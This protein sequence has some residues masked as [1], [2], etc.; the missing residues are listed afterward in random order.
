MQSLSA[1]TVV[2]VFNLKKHSANV[3]ARSFHC[4]V[5]KKLFKGQRQT[6]LSLVV[7]CPKDPQLLGGLMLRRRPTIQ[8]SHVGDGESNY[9]NHQ[10]CFSGSASTGTGVREPEL[11]LNLC[12]QYEYSVCY[13]LD[14]NICPLS[15]SSR[16]A[17]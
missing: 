3:L 5:F 8:V 9:L 16:H 6:E 10:H 13:L 1:V 14:P 7:H 2:G 15:C 4:L 17:P 11:G 12:I